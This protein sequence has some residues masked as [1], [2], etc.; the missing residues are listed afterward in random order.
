MEPITVIL[1]ALGAAGAALRPA[2]DEAVRDGYN[3]LKRLILGRYKARLEVVNLARSLVARA[4]SDS[5]GS[6][7][8][9][10]RQIDAQNVGVI[11]NNRGRVQIGNRYWWS[12]GPRFPTTRAARSV[13]AI[14]RLLVLLA[15]GSF[16]W[17]GIQSIQ[18]LISANRTAPPPAVPVVPWVPATIVL[19]LSGMA[20]GWTYEFF[21]HQPS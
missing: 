18:I 16:A 13:L 11:T 14:A 12:A 20:V 21:D 2:A 1:C 9:V 4:E 10:L 17:F 15:F 8:V 19:F 6:T 7:R 3:A 5:P